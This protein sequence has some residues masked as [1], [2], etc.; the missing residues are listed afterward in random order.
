[1]TTE[2]GPVLVTGS[3]GGVGSVA[4]KLLSHIGY[5]VIAVTGKVDQHD[6]LRKLG[7]KEV[8]SR[9]DMLDG[10]DKPLL[11]EKWGGVIDTVGGDI[12]F[13]AVKLS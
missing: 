4:I 5:D 2:S 10:K 8:I 9:E 1:M 7:A 13:N 6:F 3:T 12:L 11:P